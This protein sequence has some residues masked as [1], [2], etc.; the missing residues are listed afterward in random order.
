VKKTI[1]IIYFNSSSEIA[2]RKMG[3]LKLVN[4]MLPLT[5]GRW[6]T[7][8]TMQVIS[9]DLQAEHKVFISLFSSFQA[10]SW[11]QCL[12]EPR[13]PSTVQVLLWPCIIPFMIWWTMENNNLSYYY[14][15]Y[16][17]NQ[18]SVIMLRSTFGICVFVCCSLD[19]FPQTALR[20]LMTDESLNL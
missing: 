6:L 15:T 3:I 5:V 16:I 4:N 7:S 17:I 12:I 8:V 9:T 20:S 13:N 11:S 18:M 10:Y 19:S 2:N 1:F 14:N